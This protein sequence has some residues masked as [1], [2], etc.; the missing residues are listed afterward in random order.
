MPIDFPIAPVARRVRRYIYRLTP[1][2]ADR[3]DPFPLW[4]CDLWIAKRKEKHSGV[5]VNDYGDI[6]AG[7]IGAVPPCPGAAEFG[8][9]GWD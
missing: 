5:A 7:A 8:G 6:D 3:G 1:K 9:M 2:A 4:F